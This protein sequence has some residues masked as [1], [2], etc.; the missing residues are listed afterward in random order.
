M[1]ARD[2]FSLIGAAAS[3][4]V[5]DNALRLSAALAYYSIFSLAPLLIIIIAVAG[6]IFGEEAARGHIAD[7]MRQLAGARAAEAIQALVVGTSRKGASFSAT[8]IGLAV[9]LFGASGAF[10]ELKSAL[11]TIWGVEMKPGRAFLTMARERFISFTMVLGVGFL[12]VVSLIVSAAI[13]ALDMSMR[14]RF[15][16]PGSVW[17]WAD[18]VVS[19]G[20]MTGLFAMIFK[21]L[22]NV[23]LRWRDVWMGAACTAFL[24]TIGKFVIGIYLGTSG[25]TSYYGAA[26]SAI[27]I[28]LWVY[29]S[30]CI[31]FFGAEF[32]KAYVMKYRGRIVP[33][34]RARLLGGKG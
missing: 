24:F 19:V 1:R 20:V 22:P 14:Q 15:V 11:N 7:Q 28:L 26:G 27:V 9:L 31:L 2:F 13:S 32:T 25:V 12:M 5:E 10:G 16:M 4:W 34:G 29:Y 23:V 30:A 21:F 17:H 33:D 18:I 6:F 8:I 3:G